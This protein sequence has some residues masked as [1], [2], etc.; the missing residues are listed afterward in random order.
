MPNKSEQPENFYY[1]ERKEVN[2]ALN[3]T[4]NLI[5]SLKYYV[6]KTKSK[7]KSVEYITVV[8]ADLEGIVRY[9]LEK[10]FKKIDEGLQESEK[11][12][13][14]EDKKNDVKEPLP[15]SSL[16]RLG[17]IMRM[18]SELIKK[19]EDE[20]QKQKRVINGESRINQSKTTQPKG[21]I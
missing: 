8:I 3:K 9:Q 1:Q 18:K 2:N 6:S 19:A 5:D 16:A 13:K 10:S 20:L 14:T 7:E 11:K 21:S 4:Q 15:K 12:K 17:Q